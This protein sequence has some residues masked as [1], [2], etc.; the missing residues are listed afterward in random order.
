MLPSAEG[1]AQW[2]LSVA[3]GK[4]WSALERKCRIARA[5]QGDLCRQQKPLWQ[6]S[7]YQGTAPARPEV[8]AEPHCSLDAGKQ[9][10][11]S[12]QEALS[13]PYDSTGQRRGTS[14]DQGLGA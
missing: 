5:D 12:W 1:F 10:E 6:P 13:A 9:T 4:A 14:S 11:R 8:R 3:K 2:L 7:D